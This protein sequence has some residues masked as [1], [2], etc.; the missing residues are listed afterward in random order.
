MAV[1]KA[2]IE[3]ISAKTRRVFR[4][5]LI[6]SRLLKLIGYWEIDSEIIKP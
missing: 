1:V 6:S 5:A 3:T 4:E 2:D